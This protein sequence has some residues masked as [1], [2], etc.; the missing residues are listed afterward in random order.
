MRL[1][2]NGMGLYQLEN[3]SYLSNS[4]ISKQLR[5]IDSSYTKQK[6][7]LPKKKEAMLLYI[8]TN[9]LRKVS[10]RLG[11]PRSTLSYWFISMHPEYAK[12]CKQGVFASSSEF[13]SRSKRPRE[14]EEIETWLMKNLKELLESESNTN[15]TTYSYK[16]IKTL[17]HKE[18]SRYSDYSNSL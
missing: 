6:A 8:K 17:S 3:I 15:L 10:R 12:L 5:K 9:S 14:V 1:Y 2:L 16:K 4:L 18:T 7:W 13:M 11:V